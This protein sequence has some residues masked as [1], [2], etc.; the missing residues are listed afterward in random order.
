MGDESAAQEA[1]NGE[2]PPPTS[3]RSLPGVLAAYD[4]DGNEQWRRN[5]QEDVGPFGLN[6]GY[7]SSPL[8]YDGKLIVQV[9]HGFRT[10]D[11]SYLVAYDAVDG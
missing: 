6:F 9:L 8:L 11:P 3:R 2:R 7:A 5:V 4:M 10:D 1:P